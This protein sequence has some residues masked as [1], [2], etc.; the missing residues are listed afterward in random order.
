MSNTTFKV[1]NMTL[2]RFLSDEDIEQGLP[3]TAPETPTELDAIVAKWAR[4]VAVFGEK[5]GKGKAQV[6]SCKLKVDVL[7]SKLAD[8]IRQETIER[9]EKVVEARIKSEVTADKRMMEARKAYAEAI[10][11]EEMLLAAYRGIMRQE[12]QID[13]WAN[14]L[15]DASRREKQVTEEDARKSD[16]RRRG[17]SFKE[18]L[19]S[20]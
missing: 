5:F 3:D 12:K 16:T 8:Q 13:H 20:V 6:E 17:E 9:K 10:G 14:R 11:I 1:G 19:A 15:F 7:E 2:D 4:R 18:R